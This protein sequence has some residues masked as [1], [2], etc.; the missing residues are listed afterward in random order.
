MSLLNP[1]DSFNPTP[2]YAVIEPQRLIVT[3]VDMTIGAM[4]R[5]MVKWAIAAIP[6]FLILAALGGILS[7]IFAAM[8]GVGH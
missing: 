7:L 5:F 6:A 2:S 3:D 1:D 4:C 8:F